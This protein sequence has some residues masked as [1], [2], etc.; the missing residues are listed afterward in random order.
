MRI[1]MNLQNACHWQA[2]LE[3]RFQNKSLS[4]CCIPVH[5]ATPKACNVTSALTSNL[6]NASVSQLSV[7]WLTMLVTMTYDGIHDMQYLLGTST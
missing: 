4:S 2:S 6:S 7:I 5:S 1:D 3:N